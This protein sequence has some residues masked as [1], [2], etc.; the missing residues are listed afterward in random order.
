MTRKI[1]HSSAVTGIATA[2]IG[3]FAIG[4]GCTPD[5][6]NPYDDMVPIVNMAELVVPDPPQGSFG[7]IHSNIFRPTC[8]NS[9]CHNGFFEPDFRTVSSS[10]NTLVN[11]DV[12]SNNAA[13]SFEHRVVPGNASASFLLERLTVNIPNSSG[14]MPLELDPD[15]DYDDRREEFIAAIEA[16][17]DGGA[18]D[19]NGNAAPT[20]GTN[21]PP[22]VTGFG[23]FPVGDYEN[24]YSLDEGEGVQPFLVQPGQ[25]ELILAISDDQTALDQLAPYEVATAEIIDE[26]STSPG[27]TISAFPSPF[28][29]G[30]FSGGESTYAS[31][32]VLDISAYAPGTDI[33]LQVRLGDGQLTSVVPDPENLS[34]ITMLYRLRIAD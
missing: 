8:A 18:T 4:S 2:V 28:V 25:V 14:M 34:Y 21:L 29:A 9:G 33:Y 22:Q 13:F 23:A 16:W 7:W 15:S 19:I 31:H 30:D 27:T 10:W 6:T 20:S 26:L 12:I 5:P 24:M 32:V 1:S 3:V 11:Q 17:I